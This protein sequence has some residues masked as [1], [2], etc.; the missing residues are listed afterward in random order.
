MLQC[1]NRGLADLLASSIK[2]N[3]GCQHQSSERKQL[4][5]LVNI[6]Y[7]R[8]DPDVLVQRLLFQR[9]LWRYENQNSGVLVTHSYTY[10]YNKMCIYLC[11][12]TI[13]S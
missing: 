4:A 10:M 5:R 3:T 11:V 2:G 13:W 12:L 6:G 9:L 1:S 8:H 7:E